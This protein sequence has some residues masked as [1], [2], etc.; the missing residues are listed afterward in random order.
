MGRL[1]V[2]E[3]VVVGSAG[4]RKICVLDLS[5]LP[6]VAEGGRMWEV[7]KLPGGGMRE[8]PSRRGIRVLDG[9]CKRREEKE[10]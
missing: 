6:A 7:V 1:F 10:Y 8:M 4:V 2:V 5:T 9:S 3:P